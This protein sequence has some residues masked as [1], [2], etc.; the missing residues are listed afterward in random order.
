MLSIISN[1][2]IFTPLKSFSTFT[3]VSSITVSYLL[4]KKI[5]QESDDW[6]T[7][8]KRF[9]GAFCVTSIATYIGAS[10]C[11]VLTTCVLVSIAI[12]ALSR[13]ILHR[14]LSRYTSRFSQ[15]G[16]IPLRPPSQPSLQN[17]NPFQLNIVQER[18]DFL[19]QLHLAPFPEKE[20][21]T[22]VVEGI[23]LPFDLLKHIITYIGYK[24]IGLESLKNVA[25]VNKFFF[26]ATHAVRMQL[27]LE[28]GILG[29]NLFPSNADFLKF[30]KVH[31]SS[32]T[33][34]SLRA[35]QINDEGLKFITE[36]FG[37]L[38]KF[39]FYNS[40]LV[41][42]EGIIAIGQNMKKL[43]HLSISA[44]TFVEENAIE[45]L[46]QK[47]KNLSYLDISWC[48]NIGPYAIAA[49][50]QHCLKLQRLSLSN[51]PN[52]SNSEVEK[53]TSLTQLI[54]LDLSDTGVSNIQR[55]LRSWPKLKSLNICRTDVS[56]EEKKELAH[57]MMEQGGKCHYSP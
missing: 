26:N 31:L 2:S 6:Q 53:L 41:K 15:F 44:C 22:L 18:K 21:K 56:P 24:D 50:S 8:S 17:L 36:G 52:I 57:L 45:A 55:Y 42:N 9:L 16:V 43:T 38:T 47:L 33:S 20:I 5:I 48:E 1:N 51:C 25:I 46:V 11:P 12:F 7:K 14:G 13:E 30:L 39:E 34:L 32:S 3:A 35:T 4:Y 40:Y 37:D 27:I 28:S 19:N 23:P 29:R 54:S 10:V 49:I